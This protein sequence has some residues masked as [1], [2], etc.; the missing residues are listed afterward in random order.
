MGE[1]YLQELAKITRELETLDR[2]MGKC[3][4]ESKE[5]EDLFERRHKLQDR[6]WEIARGEMGSCP[7]SWLVR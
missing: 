1:A 2:E 3:G 7:I 4:P 6:R 5:W